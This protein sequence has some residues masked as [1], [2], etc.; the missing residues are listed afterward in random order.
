MLLD[1]EFV[2]GLLFLRVRNYN[3]SLRKSITQGIRPIRRLYLSRAKLTG[4]RGIN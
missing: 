1:K 2:L 4:V 3:F